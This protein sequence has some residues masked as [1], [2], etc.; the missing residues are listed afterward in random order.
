MLGTNNYCYTQNIKVLDLMVSDEK[1]FFT[2]SYCKSTEDDDPW[3]VANL[4]PRSMIGKIYV[5]YQVKRGSSFEQTMMGWSSICYKPSFV[6]IRPPVL[7]KILR[8]LPYMGVAAILV[9]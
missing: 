4:D 5:G 3:G 6:E 1:I 8:V 9:M 2:F 7:K